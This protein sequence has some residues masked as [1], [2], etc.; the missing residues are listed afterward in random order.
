MITYNLIVSKLLNLDMKIKD[1][2]T[3]FTANYTEDEFNGLY[4]IFFITMMNKNNFH[5]TK[6]A[7]LNE[8]MNNFYF[9]VKQNERSEFFNIFC[10][11]QK[12]YHTLNKFSYLYKY[13]KSKII[14]NNDLQLNE[15]KLGEQ[16]VICIYHINSRYLFKI[17]ELLKLIYTSLTNG[18][19]F[20][21]EPITIKN[22]Y[23]NIPFSKSILYYIYYYL[24]SY[25]KINFI[26]SN[27]LDVFLKF[28]DC[29]FNLTKFVNDHEYL[30][31]EYVIINYLNNT[32][33]E[34]IKIE[35]HRMI[36]FYNSKFRNSTIEISDNFP[37]D[38]LIKV[39]KPYLHLKLISDYSLIELKKRK[40]KRKL[41]KKLYEFHK[42]NPLFGR[43]FIKFKDVNVNGKIKKIKSHTEFSTSYKKFN[44]YEID[45]FMKNHL[46]YKYNDYDEDDIEEEE[47][48][49]SYY[50]FLF[51]SEFRSRRPRLS[52]I[53]NNYDEEESEEESEEEEEEQ[54]QQQEEEEEEEDQDSIS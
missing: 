32:S 54:L 14:V 23:N 4:K 6:F 42:F 5:K 10:K 31:R 15:I 7:C 3:I 1:N 24:I 16:N 30:L 34:I 29:N 38:L 45:N 33:K 18:F 41:Y 36:D 12:I 22:P 53:A 51:N 47:S 2:N 19:S 9:N 43:Q 21:C 20:F 50:F 35:I 39:M 52:T 44:N 26:N 28:K 37:Q 25:T 11:I 27:H 40:A 17:N 49:N 8:I 46:N 48:T 13:K